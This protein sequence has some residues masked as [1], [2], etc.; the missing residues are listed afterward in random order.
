MKFGQVFSLRIINAL[1]SYIK[2]SKECFIR[3]PNT[4]N[5]VQNTWQLLVFSTHFLVLGYLMSHSSLCLIYGYLKY[6]KR[7]GKS[8]DVLSTVRP[9]VRLHVVFNFVERQ[10]WEKIHARR[11]NTTLGERLVSGLRM[12]VT[13][14]ERQK[15]GQNTSLNQ[16]TRDTRQAPKVVG[17]SRVSRVLRVSRDACLSPDPS[18]AM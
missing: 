7:I 4:S 18:R 11:E 10:R 8:F 14:V 3:Y 5:L 1:R 9:I 15:S 13:F 17:A 16:R 12:V 2:H 6:R